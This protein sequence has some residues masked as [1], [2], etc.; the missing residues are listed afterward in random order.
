MKKII[1]ILLAISM[2]F[3][4]F[5]LFGCNTCDHIY[6]EN[7]VKEYLISEATCNYS[8]KYYKSCKLCGQKSDMTFI[9]GEPE[10]SYIDGVCMVCSVVKPTY[11]M[12][13]V[14][15][16]ETRVKFGEYPQERVEDEDKIN[17]LN[18]LAGE[19]P[20]ENDKKD[21]TSID[22]YAEKQL[23][24]MMWYK[25]VVYQNK[26]YRGVHFTKYKPR[27]TEEQSLDSAGFQYNKGYFVGVTYWF[28]WQD[29]EWRVLTDDGDT[30]F[31]MVNSGI[32]AVSF[33]HDSN[34][35]RDTS[36]NPVDNTYDGEIIYSNNYAY[37]N[38][39]KWL[40]DNFYNTAFSEKEKAIIV[41]SEVDNSARTTNP[42]TNP[43]QFSGGVNEYACENTLDKVFMA[44]VYDVTNPE[45]GFS[46]NTTSD[47]S[48]RFKASDYAECMGA[49]SESARNGNVYMWL[50]SSYNSYYFGMRRI[51]VDGELA[52]N[53]SVWHSSVAPGIVVNISLTQ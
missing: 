24:E 2:V 43:H 12:Y 15:D 36:G 5:C 31:L 47:L 44:S 48:R 3:S 38:V 26:R 50:R 22:C 39:R 14:D 33:F 23:T 21:W 4:V 1:S 32:D 6:V 19:L 27:S 34:L 42:C 45:Y 40:N 7:A 52:I 10:H 11:L 20:N 18:D 16:V 28:K 17:S 29:I 51:G 25:D 46:S 30:A 37:S 13:V 8:A 35:Y 41:L 9:K 49:S 53:S